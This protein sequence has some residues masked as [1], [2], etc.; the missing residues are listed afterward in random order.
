MIFEA[1]NHTGIHFNLYLIN[2][3]MKNEIKVPANML[4]FTALQSEHRVIW[5]GKE[6]LS[7]YLY[8]LVLLSKR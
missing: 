5:A 6:G 7:S 8:I 2:K 1:A 4:M 3:L